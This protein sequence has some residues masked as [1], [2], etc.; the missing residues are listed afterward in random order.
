MLPW[1]PAF[2]VPAE[3]GGSTVRPCIPALDVPAALNGRPCCPAALPWVFLGKLLDADRPATERAVHKAMPLLVR[4]MN[5][6]R[7]TMAADPSQYDMR[8]KVRACVHP[9]IH[10][11]QL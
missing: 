5:A 7:D 1:W 10:S 3:L 8:C 4:C 6:L 9:D 11:F 2:G